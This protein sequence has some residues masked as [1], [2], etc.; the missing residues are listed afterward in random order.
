M[1]DAHNCTEAMHFHFNVQYFGNTNIRYLE[2]TAHCKECNAKA[3]FRGPPGLNP[4]HPTVALDGTEAVFPFLFEGEEY[5]GNAMALTYKSS[6]R[7]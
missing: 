4:S 5:D 2:V 6:G 3:I 1:A 7:N